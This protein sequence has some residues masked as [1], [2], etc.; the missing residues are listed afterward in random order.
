M[1]QGQRE[2]LVVEEQDPCCGKPRVCTVEAKDLCPDTRDRQRDGG[3]AEIEYRNGP[4]GQ[5]PVPAERRR[6]LCEDQ[7]R[8]EEVEVDFGDGLEE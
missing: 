3:E 7:T 5:E 2:R 1:D 8:R 4:K 6:D